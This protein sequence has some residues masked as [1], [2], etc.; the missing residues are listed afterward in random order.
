LK[1]DKLLGYYYEK[2]GWDDRGIPTNDTMK[3]LGLDEEA[4]ELDEL[5]KLN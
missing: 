4:K 3:K 1:Y 5:V 2:R